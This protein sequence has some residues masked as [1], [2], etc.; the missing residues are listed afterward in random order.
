[1]AQV[2]LRWLLQKPNVSSVIIG[3][4]TMEQLEDNLGAGKGWKL[5]DEEVCPF[6]NIHRHTLVSKIH[7]LMSPFFVLI[8]ASTHTHTRT[9]I[10]MLLS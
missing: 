4:R 10:R 9:N 1:M 7:V 2:S 6:V 8:Y 3:P 5:T